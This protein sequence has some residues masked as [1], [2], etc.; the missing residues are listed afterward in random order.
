LSTLTYEDSPNN[1]RLNGEIELGQ[2]FTIRAEFET[3]YYCQQ[4]SAEHAD[5]QITSL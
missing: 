3:G 2:G 5:T 1:G 4:H